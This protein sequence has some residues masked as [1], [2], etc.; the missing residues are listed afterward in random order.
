MRTHREPRYRNTP[1]PGFRHARI[2]T[3]LAAASVAA[4][5]V[6]IGLGTAGGTYAYFDAS[7]VGGSA[8][9]TAGTAQLEVQADFTADEWANLLVGENVRQPYTIVNSGDVPLVLTASGTTQ[10]GDYELRTVAGECPATALA[11]DSLAQA[12]AALGTLGAG[13]SATA[14]LE[15]R[16]VSGTPGTSSTVTITVTG[17]QAP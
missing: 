17:T 7:T 2:R 6:V 10:S 14:C 16:L 9:I 12:P 13:A 11:G 3:L 4:A 5:G 15:V 8:V 1:V